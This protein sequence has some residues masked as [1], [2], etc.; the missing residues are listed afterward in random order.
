[1]QY[2]NVTD[3]ENSLVH[4]CWDLCDANNTSY[5]LDGKVT[6]RFNI[7]L[8]R[9]IGWILESDGTWQWDDTNYTTLPIGTQ[10]LVNSQGVYSF[11]DKF[12]ELELVED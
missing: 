9:V 7:A 2:Y 3:T 6:R 10:T 4:E 11:N 1:M 5:P 8:E 12:L